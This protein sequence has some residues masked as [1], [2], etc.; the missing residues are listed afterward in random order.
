MKKKHKKNDAVVR[1]HFVNKYKDCS[2]NLCAQTE[3][4][5]DK[6]YFIE[7]N[8]IVLCRGREGRWTI[9]AGVKT[10]V[11]KKTKTPFLA[12]TLICN[13]VQTKGI[14]VVAPE[15]ALLIGNFV[16]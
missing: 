13:T 15:M 16:I 10:Q 4:D 2:Y 12:V 14:R 8:D 7:E 6:I 3:N 1:A 5:V 11:L 9:L